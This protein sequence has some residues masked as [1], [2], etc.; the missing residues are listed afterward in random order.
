MARRPRGGQPG[1][2][3][4]RTHGYYSD[5]LG[6]KARKLLKRAHLIDPHDLEEEIDL[7]RV[8]IHQLTDNDPD[9]IAVLTL[10]GGL[11]V[12]MIAL[13]NGLSDEQEA[14]IHDSFKE[15]LTSLAP[16]KR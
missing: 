11:L 15:L 12:R 14:G 5:A 8:K 3:N 16:A 4:A 6:P 10:A 7:M 1:N 9:N 2:K 13:H